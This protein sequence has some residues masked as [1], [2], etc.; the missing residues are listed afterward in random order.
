MNR[1]LTCIAVMAIF[2]LSQVEGFAAELSSS[3]S[4]ELSSKISQQLSDKIPN[5]R[6]KIPSLSHL[7]SLSPLSE[8]VV[9]NATRFIEDK[10]SGIAV[11]EVMGTT[12]GGRE[13]RQ[14]IQTP[15]EAWVDV[16]TANKRIFPNSKLKSEDFKVD[17]VNVATGMAREYRGILVDAKTDFDKMESR[18]TILEG[19]LVTRTSIQKQP[20]VRKGEMVKLE[21][22][23][24]DLSLVT[25]AIAQEPGAIGDRVRVLTLKT[26]KEIVGKIRADHSIEVNL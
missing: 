11:I 22:L 20:D 25:Q 26:K 14:I 5:S 7:T 24:G 19:Q 1:Q 6:I 23:S 16:P 13:V 21:L 10:P 3:L 2:L 9:L 8:I 18:Q 4:D 12:E 17:A 15:Y